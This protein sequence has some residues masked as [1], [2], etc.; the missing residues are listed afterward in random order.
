MIYS[1]HRRVQVLCF[2][3]VPTTVS[4]P[5]PAP[6][7]S[8]QTNNLS[9]F[10][11]VLCILSISNNLFVFFK[12]PSI[13]WFW[14][15]HFQTTFYPLDQRTFGFQTTLSFSCFISLIIII[16]LFFL[17]RLLIIESLLIICLELSNEYNYL[18][19][20][21]LPM[22]HFLRK[23]QNFNIFVYIDFMLGNYIDN[24]C[25]MILFWRNLISW[26]LIISLENFYLG[27]DSAS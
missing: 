5:P 16:F 14:F 13:Y 4:Q 17:W 20:I 9:W 18:Y 3:F 25:V 2:E 22:P 24:F 27:K 10:P 26:V 12:L 6:P 21:L 7:F 11:N 1:F 15:Y 23:V 8:H 19:F